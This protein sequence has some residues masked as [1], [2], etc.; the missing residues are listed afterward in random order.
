MYAL[1]LGLMAV[2][3]AI[4][5]MNLMMSAPP[6]VVLAPIAGVAA[7]VLGVRARR[8]ARAN[9]RRAPGSVGGITFGIIGLAFSVLL[10]ASLAAVW[11]EFSAFRTCTEGAN[12][13][14]AQSACNKTFTEDLR[15]RAGLPPGSL[16][17]LDPGGFA[18]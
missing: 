4:E 18:G 14:T 12:T 8:R 9:D 7:V 1:F 17:S 10:F 16:P 13:I 6:L 3:L 5:I 2:V 15:K 11:P